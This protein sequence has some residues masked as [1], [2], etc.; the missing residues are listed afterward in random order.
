[1]NIELINT[2]SE[3]MLG[4]VLNSHQQWI[5]RQ[6]ADRGYVVSR[7]VAVPDTGLDI[8]QA[9]RDGLDRADLVLVTGGLGPTSDDITRDKI[10]E[11]LGVRLVRDAD[12]LATLERFYAKR[13]RPVPERALVQAYAPTG[14]AVLDNQHGTAPGLAMKVPARRF[15]RGAPAKAKAWLIM[16]PGPPRELRPMF[17]EQVVPLLQREFPQKYG[18]VCRTL[19]STGVPESQME[20]IVAPVLAPL[21]AKGLELGYCARNGE[22]DVRL[23][24]RGPQAPRLVAHAEKVVRAKVDAFLFG[25]EDALLEEVV[26]RL[27]TDKRKTL[28]LAESCTGGFIAHRLT[29]ISGASAVLLAGLVSYSNESK[30]KFLGVRTGTL[31]SHGA[32]SEAVARQMAEGARTR[33]GADF[34]VAVTGVA[35]P[36]GGSIEKPVGT[37]F[38]AIAG[39]GPTLV[40]KVFNPFDRETFKYVTA[41]QALELV[42]RRVL[43]IEHV[44]L[45]AMK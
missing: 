29:N 35:G 14:A 7:Q 23:A 28:A 18:F 6:L 43:R 3:L 26:V 37:A 27:L 30:Q 22:V 11:L 31:A 25:E 24:A 8:Q 1:M 41:Q 2:G 45:P 44:E 20:Q 19:R 15:R 21:V 36:T 12:A 9:V 40:K 32:V 16:L 38:L 13:D 33:T 42:R 17:L 10:A 4:R 39:G 34:A 5:C